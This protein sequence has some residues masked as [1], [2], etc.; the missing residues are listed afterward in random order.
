MVSAK[1][2]VSS[3]VSSR[4]FKFFVSEVLKQQHRSDE[5]LSLTRCDDDLFDA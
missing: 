3:G 5:R 1:D 2:P 4:I